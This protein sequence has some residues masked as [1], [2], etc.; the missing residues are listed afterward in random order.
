[1]GLRKSSVDLDFLS[2]LV[3]E[4]RGV[5]D[6]RRNPR[7][8]RIGKPRMLNS[9]GEL[10]CPSRL[11]WKPPACFNISNK[12]RLGLASY[13]KDCARDYHHWYADTLRGTMVTKL[14]N[15]A[16][17]A[18][19][20]GRSCDLTLD[21]LLNKLLEQRARCYY[22]GV[23]MALTR[24]SDWR[25]SLERLCNSEGY[26]IQNCVWVSNEFNTPD[27]SINKAKFPV[28][29]TAQWSKAKVEF[30]WGAFS[31]APFSRDR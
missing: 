19:N 14:A 15:A 9:L 8:R 3:Q 22:S 10:E 29:G 17:R 11:E 4:A 25:I 5:T 28:H 18:R 6:R 20:R 21:C 2:R 31:L 1:M 16:Q 12:S 26:T 7:V 30:V 24:Y 27:N 13:C 23:P